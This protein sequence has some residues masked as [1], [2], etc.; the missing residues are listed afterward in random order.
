MRDHGMIDKNVYLNTH[1]PAFAPYLSGA[2]GHRVKGTCEDRHRDRSAAC[3][4]LNGIA[5]FPYLL[6]GIA[7]RPLPRYRY[8][9]AFR[10]CERW[11]N[12]GRNVQPRRWMCHCLLCTDEHRRR[13]LRKQSQMRSPEI[14]VQKKREM[15]AEGRTRCSDTCRIMRE[16]DREP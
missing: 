6:M 14:E 13:S 4:H 9:H 1:C 10:V 11:L 8:E 7:V 12:A 5:R 15:P 3:L 16:Q 2:A